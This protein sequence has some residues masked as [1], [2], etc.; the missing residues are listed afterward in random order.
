MRRHYRGEGRESGR[1]LREADGGMYSLL[2]RRKLLKK[3]MEIIAERRQGELARRLGEAVDRYTDKE[4][5][6]DIARAMDIY[7]ADKLE[8]EKNR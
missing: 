6:G 5:A 2:I 4:A 8:K 3:A 7:T 1:G